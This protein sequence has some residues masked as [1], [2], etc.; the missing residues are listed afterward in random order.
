MRLRV[1]KKELIVPAEHELFKACH[2]STFVKMPSGEYLIAFFAGEREGLPDTG[3]WISAYRGEKW[4]T[5]RKLL[6]DGT[7]HWNPVLFADES[8]VVLY[9]KVGAN[10][11][12][13]NTYYTYSD[14]N[15]LTWSERKLLCPDEPCSRGPVRNKII[16]GKDG[17]LIAPGS[18]ETE[19]YFDCFT[20]KSFDGGKT[21][22]KHDIPISHR[23]GSPIY[24]KN[25]WEGLLKKELWEND[26]STIEKWDGILQPTLFYGHDGV[27]HAFLRSTR[28]HIY[29]SDSRD[30]GNTWC[31][32]YET[33]LPS[34]NAGIDCE[35]MPDGRLV[36]VCNPIFG[37]WAR[38]TP[39]S[40]Y[41]SEDDGESF[42]EPFPIE[43]LEGELSY[44]S[45]N[46]CDGKL[47][48]T[49]TYLRRS[50]MHCICDITT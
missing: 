1:L 40:L 27:L 4:E 17:S 43:T 47:H 34:N 24:R 7:P 19:R 31:E 29:K 6:S 12:V 46:Y 23:N 8:R 2:A 30:D 26:F 13:W 44:P 21:W 38:R 48:I 9:Y 50:I 10:T 41:V 32:A 14:D 18:I 20:E 16:H 42:S 37:N 25:I 3:I 35:M 28:G 33:Q 49:F 15:G 11:N 39:I 36:L 45:V 22:E 5:P